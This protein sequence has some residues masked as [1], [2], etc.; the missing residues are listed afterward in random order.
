MTY[1]TFAD[2]VN[3][4]LDTTRQI[5]NIR[6]ENSNYR[7]HLGK[8]TEFSNNAFEPFA[9]DQMQ[10]HI[11]NVWTMFREQST[12]ITDDQ[13]DTNDDSGFRASDLN[14]AD[15]L[16]QEVRSVHDFHS[17]L[18]AV[19]RERDSNGGGGQTPLPWRKAL[20]MAK[21]VL[22]SILSIL[23]LDKGVRALL[24]V[25]GEAIDLSTTR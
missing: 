18:L 22:E 12:L 15:L 9:Q 4:L 21:T 11:Q 7:R 3:K 6:A 17:K 23:E 1:M 10:E 13:L 5:I 25:A 16:H 14:A 8:V 24:T 20:K 2:D 19:K